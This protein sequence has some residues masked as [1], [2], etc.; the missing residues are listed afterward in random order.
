M[1]VIQSNDLPIYRLI[2]VLKDDSPSLYKECKGKSDLKSTINQLKKDHTCTTKSQCEQGQFYIY[3][4][5]KS[6]C[7]H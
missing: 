7:K 3:V 5:S 1:Q 4:E 2:A 6:S